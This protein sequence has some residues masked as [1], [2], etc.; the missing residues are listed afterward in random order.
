MGQSITDALWLPSIGFLM[1][2]LSIHGL[3]IAQTMPGT[4]E[5]GGFRFHYD[6]N[7]ISALPYLLECDIK[8][9]GM[10]AV[11]LVEGLE[12][13]AIGAKP[14]GAGIIGE[15]FADVVGIQDDRA[16]V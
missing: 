9:H 11:H 14:Q 8:I 16:P 2:F 10:A 5:K 6:E 15:G 1:L 12:I 4:I 3:A 13:L 7:G